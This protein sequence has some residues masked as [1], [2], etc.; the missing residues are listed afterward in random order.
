MRVTDIIRSKG[1]LVA[2]VAPGDT[3]D[4]AVAKLAELG[5]GALIVLS[6]D[7]GLLG[8][9]SERDIVRRL[10]TDG[11]STLERGVGELMTAEVVTCD[12]HDTMAELMELMT[13]RRI[14]HVPV[15]EDGRVCAV[16]S[17]GD[18]VKA[19]LAELEDERR[20]LEDYITRG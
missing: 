12:P 2:S 19:R 4:R 1:D 14:R 5:I 15:V 11:G 10:H 9:L 13:Q 7:G 16:V 8:I 6:D 17:I 3:I 18:V 20:H